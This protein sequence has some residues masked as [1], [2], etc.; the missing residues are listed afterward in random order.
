MAKEIAYKLYDLIPSQQTMY[1]MV[2]YSIHKQVIQIPSAIIVNEKLDFD[3]LKK[4]L[5]IEFER[6]DALRLRFTKTDGKI[7]QYFLP[8]YKN[9]NIPVLNFK[10]KQEQDDYL[11]KDAQKPVSFLK[12]ETFRIIFYRTFDSRTGIYF[13]SSHM[14]TDALGQAVFYAD[15]LAVYKALEN[16]SEMPK[17]LYSFEEHIHREFEYLT[18]EKLHSKDRDFYINYWKENGEPFYAGIHGPNLLE[19]ARKKDPN[20]RVPKV[21]D[22]IHDKT[23]II[24]RFVSAEDTEKIYEYCK[25]ELVIPEN[26]FLYG[27]RA[28]ASK[29]NYRTPDVLNMLICSRRAVYKD[30]MM[31]GC[32]A[33]P[34]Q[35]R[36]IT[37]ETDTF[38]EAVGKVASCR[39]QLI[40]HMNFPYLEARLLQQKEFGYATSQGP[41]CLMFSWMPIGFAIKEHNF[42]VEFQAYSNGRFSMPLYIFAVPDAKTG[43]TDFYYMY[44]VH[45]ISADQIN[46]LHD[47]AMKAIK[48]GIENPDI[49]VGELLDN[50]DDLK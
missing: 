5:N 20:I 28:H 41:S 30:K 26:V 17:P 35:I 34:L 36:V 9:D 27:L 6:N 16:G 4:A 40:R 12:G 31:G 37:Q 3:L 21:F 19:K 46:L 43:G 2:K 18:N 33:Q 11:G 8:S 14:I 10:T 29:I 7:K 44:R 38:R 24:R 47:N 49:T 15:L 1:L 32:V 45:T 50:M 42:D 23:A 13:N 22:P 39:N 25:K 48:M